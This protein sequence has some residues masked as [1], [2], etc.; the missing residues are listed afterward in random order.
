MCFTLYKIRYN[1]N[2]KKVNITVIWGGSWTF[3]VLYW[4]KTFQ[5]DIPK[6]LAAIIAMTDSWGTAWEIR[7]KYWVLPP[8]DIRR[9]IAA[10]AEDTG[11]VRELF[12]YQFNWEKWV[13]WW[14]KLWN[15]LLTALN[16]IK[17]W[18]EKWLDEACKMFRVN[19]KVIPVT[20]DDVHLGV[21]FED[22]TEVIWEKHI[23]V[24][25]T[26]PWEKSHNTD[27]NI[28]EAFLVGWEW[29][30]N[31]NAKEAI[32]DSDIIIIWPW[33]FYTSIIPNL[34][35]PWMREALEKTDA[36]VVYVCNIMADKWETTT[37]ELPDFI[38]NVEKYTWEVI[39]YVFV[40]SWHISDELVEKYRLEWKKP[41]KL[42]DEM[43][44]K[45]KN[46]KIIERDFLDESD[47]IRHNPKKISKV[48]IDLYEGWIK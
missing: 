29:K 7:D 35:C 32:L 19:W 34:L 48:I 11:L 46:Y 24:S 22:W 44:F 47:Y 41:V 27:Q 12:E 25:D 4:L 43:N 17:W 18:F 45:W 20:L 33:D 30:L 42:K 39:D 8:W 21:K 1:M 26:N 36:T 2:N 10:L 14:N 3:N 5:A 40:N 6:N 9:G 13:I 31:P 28:K 38:D 16:D 15:I 23:D 37:Y